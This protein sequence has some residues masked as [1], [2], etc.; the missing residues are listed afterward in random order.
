MNCENESALLESLTLAQWPD[1]STPE[2][3]E[4][5]ATCIDCSSLLHVA[6]ALLSDRSD[7]EHAASPSQSG[8]VWKRMQLRMRHEAAAEAARAVTQAQRL[9]YFATAAI[10]IVCSSL[11]SVGAHVVSWFADRKLPMPEMPVLAMPSLELQ[12]PAISMAAPPLAI[13][14]LMSIT[15]LVFAP[16]AVYLAFAKD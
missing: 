5:V 15:A 16:V 2:L 8:I 6:G 3:R 12:L 7:L 4:H 14:A 1:C 11:Y 13:L 9:A 10:V